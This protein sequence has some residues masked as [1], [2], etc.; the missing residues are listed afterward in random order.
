M[1]FFHTYHV[2]GRA[3]QVILWCGAVDWGGFSLFFAARWKDMFIILNIN[4]LLCDRILLGSNNLHCYFYTHTLTKTLNG[5]PKT[6]YGNWDN[7]MALMWFCCSIFQHLMKLS[8]L[9]CLW[10]LSN[11]VSRRNRLI[12][13]WKVSQYCGSA[14][15]AFPHSLKGNTCWQQNVSHP[16]CLVPACRVI[17]LLKWLQSQIWEASKPERKSPGLWICDLF[18]CVPQEP[19]V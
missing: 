5:I 10:T 6:K 8:N 4:Q 16:F 14:E 9:V 3:I 17:L 12:W 2:L 18:K 7:I 19:T 15:T 11:F 1:W 13:E